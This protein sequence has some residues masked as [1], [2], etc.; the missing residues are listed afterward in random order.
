MRDS[1]SYMKKNPL[2]YPKL[3]AL[4]WPNPPKKRVSEENWPPGLNICFAGRG[5]QGTPIYIAPSFWGTGA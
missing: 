1:S 2:R 3:S 5:Y 4:L